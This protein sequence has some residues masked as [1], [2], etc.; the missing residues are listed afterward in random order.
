[1]FVNCLCLL[2]FSR[3]GIVQAAALSKRIG[4]I[5]CKINYSESF[6][7]STLSSVLMPLCKVL[8]GGI[9]ML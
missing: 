8:M 3:G 7:K 5:C 6:K 4:K 2:S 1:M 9:G